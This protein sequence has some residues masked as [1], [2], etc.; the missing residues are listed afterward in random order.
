M[1]S[2]TFISK[3]TWGLACNS[4]KNHSELMMKKLLHVG[5]NRAHFVRWFWIVCFDRRVLHLYQFNK[6]W[7]LALKCFFYK[8]RKKLCPIRGNDVF[9]M[10]VASAQINTPAQI[11]QQPVE[12]RQIKV[13]SFQRRWRDLQTNCELI[14]LCL[15]RMWRDWIHLIWAQG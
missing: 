6:Q 2:S 14:V 10:M 3:V 15:F 5:M 7:N 8:K 1:F 13:S 9:C 11:F 12:M 4:W